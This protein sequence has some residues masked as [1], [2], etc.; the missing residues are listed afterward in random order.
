[1]KSSIV[2]KTEN[3]RG[4]LTYIAI[5]S[6]R[7]ESVRFAPISVSTSHVG[8]GMIISMIT[9]TSSVTI[10]MSLCRVIL[11]TIEAAREVMALIG[12]LPHASRR[13]RRDLRPPA[14]VR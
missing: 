14:R 10:A 13:P 12:Q 4:V 1:M 3:S 9:T 6:M 2:G 11:E 5:I 8:S 7:N